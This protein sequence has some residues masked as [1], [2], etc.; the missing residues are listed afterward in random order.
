VSA[1][2]RLDLTSRVLCLA[3]VLGLTLAFGESSTALQGV[4]LLTVLA[5]SASVAGRI[6]W[7]RYQW[8]G[9]VEG[10][11]A[12]IVIGVTMP[13][14]A[15]LLPYLMVPALLGGID[16]GRRATVLVVGSEAFGL[17]AALVLSESNAVALA[18]IELSAPWIVASLG[19]GF[20]AE[21][22]LLLRGHTALVDE[23]SYLSA[24]RLLTQL[25][26]VTRRLSSGLDPVSIG[27]QAL[28]DVEAAVI[29]ARSALFLRTVSGTWTPL[30]FR[31]IDARADLEPG[32]EVFDVCVRDVRP[33]EAPQPSGRA[34]CRFRFAFPVH[35]GD[36]LIGVVLADGPAPL[37]AELGTL[38]HVMTE[39]ALRLDAA[40]VFDEVRSL[41]T[42]EERQRIAREIHDGVAQELASL[43]YL[44]DEL[45]D[46][47]TTEA[48]GRRLSNLRGE[49]TRVVNE[50]RLSIFDL[51]SEIN[52]D[53]GL[54]SA[55]ST[56]VRTVGARSGLTVHLTLD[57]APRRLRG[58]VES[59]LLRIAQEAVTNARKHS[60]GENL[61]V[62]CRIQPPAAHISIRDDGGG[63]GAA[64][65]DSYGIKIMRERAERIGAQL[66]IR[67][68]PA[69]TGGIGTKVTV[70][71]S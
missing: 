18:A 34:D 17:L 54:G 6:T 48:Q 62:D 32:G 43:G 67:E 3:T 27:N 35:V 40:L 11:A 31:G 53:G 56:Y 4:L 36:N 42:V 10:L 64:R 44:V 22:I 71:L 30:V 50:L 9:I 49:I 39:H 8:L 13:D 65:R 55:L 66:D 25:R 1:A 63:L 15:L 38:H 26:S 70:T 5:A 20:L 57:E 46:A 41:A 69:A 12:G 61:W 24:R 2:S 7:V 51:R 68:E 21:W 58:D 19:V 59:E 28:A 47:A 16:G 29:S 23:Q 33:V 60:N 14:G 37:V 52:A 45:A